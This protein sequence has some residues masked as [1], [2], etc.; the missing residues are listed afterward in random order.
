MKDVSIPIPNFNENEPVELEVKVGKNKMK[1]YFRIVS[2]PWETYEDQEDESIG[3]SLFKI[4]L[5]KKAIKNYDKG[6]EL[7]QIYTPPKNAK[8]I[9]ILYR[10]K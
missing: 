6:W 8:K 5:L 7:I 4:N 9:E 1:Y 3:N 10:K 2:F